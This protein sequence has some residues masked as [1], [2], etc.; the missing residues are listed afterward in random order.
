MQIQFEESLMASTAPKKPHRSSQSSATHFT[1]LVELIDT[2]P[3]IWRRI[4][5]DGRTR[6]DAFH[7]VLQAA[8]GWTDSH[9]HEFEISEKFYGTPDLDFEDPDHEVLIEKKFRLNQLLA[10]GDICIYLYDFGD[11]WSHRITVESIEEL[12]DAHS[13]ARS[14]WVEAGKRACPPEDA[15]G[16]GQYQ[17]FLESLEND[18]YGEETKRIREW[19]GLDFDPERFD[20]R[21]ANNA[22]D[23]MLWNGWIRIGT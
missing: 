2:E 3:C 1:V 15:G 21:A 8:M 20:R 23:R 16:V 6:L 9:L 13:N 10:T 19:A 12:G 4:H 5:I 7:H 18:P 22:I 14:A 11:S 17:D